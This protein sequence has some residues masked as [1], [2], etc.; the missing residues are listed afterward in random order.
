MSLRFVVVLAAAVL[1]APSRAEVTIE[2]VEGELLDNLREFVRG[3]PDCQAERAAVDD[4][5][6]TLP[7]AVRPALDAF[8]YYRARVDATVMPPAKAAGGESPSCWHIRARVA[9]GEPVRVGSVRIAV[10]GAAH[11][12]PA[13][14]GL[15][16]AFPLP[17]G[18]V[19]EHQRYATFKHQ[20]EAL[21]RER[22]YIDGRFTEQR[23]DVYVERSAADI[24]LTFDSG[25]RYDF[26]PVTFDTMAL[27]PGVLRSFVDFAE[28]QPYDAAAVNRLQRDLTA[29]RYFAR[30]TAEPQFA[31][32]VDGEI[33]IR[34]EAAPA[35]PTSYSVGGG[36]S[37]DDGPRFSFSYDNV[38]RNAAGHQIDGSLLLAQVRQN[39]AFEYRVPHGNPQRD[40]LSYRAGLAREDVTAGV[41]AVARIG[42]RHTRASDA[43]TATRFLDALYEHDDDLG[44]IDL[45]TRLL[46]PGISWAR[47]QRDSLTR[48]R[49]G[50]RVSVNVS[51]GVG[52]LTLAQADFRG[53]WI[54]ATPW[55]ARIIVRGRVGVTLEN[56]DFARLPLSMR[57]FAGGDNSVRGYEFE[58]LGPRDA[59]GRLIGGDRLLEASVEY[60]HPI[61]EAWAAAVFVDAGN[62]F[63]GSDLEARVGAGIGA[64][65]FSPIG[66]VRVDVAWPINVAPGEDR[67]P[68]LH[69]SLGPDL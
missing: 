57:F 3:E 31:A 66:P 16:A 37:T 42:F 35:P 62:A 50:H 43:F 19:L 53:K 59:V 47:S 12:D 7:M 18:S 68:R 9:L 58:S 27:A 14:Q 39:A 41:G 60:E 2:G 17:E 32:A 38:R 65:W 36:F 22:G 56:A 33:P 5:A 52:D 67:S 30:A 51:L 46:L 23:I 6:A 21:A 26:G 69:I 4:F 40:W 25:T 34:V 24:A 11:D 1:A 54:Q 63:L 45:T 13:L 55:D 44:G 49:E 48:P 61:R 29:S 8:G 15:V 64:R 20:L 10:V 28:G